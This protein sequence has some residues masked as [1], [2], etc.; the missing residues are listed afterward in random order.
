MGKKAKYA[1]GVFVEGTYL[2][3]VCL[4]QK[5]GDVRL[6]DAEISRIAVKMDAVGATQELIPDYSDGLDGD[7]GGDMEGISLSNEL[8]GP[9]ILLSDVEN[10]IVEANAEAL[11]AL[12]AKYADKKYKM[13]ISLAEPQIYYAYFNSDWNLKGE[14]LKK[15]VI[16]ELAKVRPD[17]DLLKPQ[18]IN[19][20]KL[21]D[22][23]LMAI[24]RDGEISVIGELEAAESGISKRISFVES[25]EVSLVNLIK[26]SYQFPEET[27]NLIIY[28]GHEFSRLTFMRG[29]EIVNISYI[30]GV[31]LDS[32]NIVNTIYSRIL[33]EQDNLNLPMLDHVILTGQA[34]DAGIDDF[35]RQKF[36][37]ETIIE[38]INLQ[39]LG[40][41][42]SDPLSSRFAIPIGS[43]LRALDDKSKNYYVM[44]LTPHEVKESK[45]KFKLG[46]SGWVIL[47]LIPIITF[48]S[49]IK[50]AEQQSTLNQ[51]E[52]QIRSKKV[53]L[54]ELQEMEMRL[55]LLRQKLS[56]FDKTLGVLDSIP[57]HNS[58]WSQFLA[59]I[60]NVAQKTQHV[61][62]TDASREGLE[63]VV[64]RGYSV[65][66]DKIPL[67]V[68]SL[69][70]ARLKR[71]EVQEIRDK[72]V[73]NFELEIFIDQ[74]SFAL[75]R[76]K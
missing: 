67:F 57:L 61:W 76:V 45:K 62:I 18:D 30:I 47:A 15:R 22:G 7:M 6:V 24:V 50:I 8:S 64:M 48:F 43:A 42:G 2:H 27:I 53:E 1:V 5:D 51:Q 13:A 26:Q 68:N 69:E 23:R 39:Q 55:N 75:N 56:T 28:I 46:I 54:A 19:L 72:T 3:F 33:L 4:M 37:T 34:F 58:T 25:A 38:Y 9:D 49:T 14:K 12:L 66:R 32:E 17:A 41:A 11:G 63:K 70:N 36:P 29:S 73:Y 10:E 71:V 74:K 60:S 31:G 44:D 21:Q 16:E 52:M 20:I 65:Y 40:L 35:L 59:Q